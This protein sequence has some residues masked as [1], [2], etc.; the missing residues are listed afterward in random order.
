MQGHFLLCG[1]R[2]G[3][4][5]IIE[6]VLISN[7]DISPD[8]IV[9]INEAP[10]QIEQL[11]SNPKFKDLNFIAGD[12]TDETTLNRAYIHTASRALVISDRSKDY[13]NLEIDSRTVL[14]VLTMESMS[15]GIYIAAELIS[16][17]FERHLKMAHCDEIILTQEYERS[18][19]AT[20]SSGQ[21]YS[22][23]IKALISDDADSGIIIDDIPDGFIGKTYKDF[24]DYAWSSRSK[25][26][27]LV[28]LL[29]NSGNFHLRRMEA[30]REAQKNPNINA[31]IDSLKKV[32]SLVSNEPLL[33]PPNDYVVPKN[34]KAIF[35]RGKKQAQ[36]GR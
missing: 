12:F 36:Q 33:T 1:W 14:A 28:G 16:E 3:F 30:I 31:I 35:V 9:L 32:K 26:G 2:P 4:E 8:L 13:S 25:T 10:D 6:N 17:K 22:N 24:K 5:K 27:I 21:G 23:V 15:R 20:A 29:L 34:A 18:L 7:P 11:R 19:L